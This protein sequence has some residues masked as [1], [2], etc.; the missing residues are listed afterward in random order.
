VTPPRRRLVVTV[1][2][3]ERGCVTLPPRRGDRPRRLDARAITGL[4]ESLVAARGLASIVAVET[5]CAGGCARPGPNVSVTTYPAARDGEPVS[6][7]AIAW[8]TYVYSLSRLASVERIVDD[9]LGRRPGA[10]RLTRSSLRAR[11][12]RAGAPRTPGGR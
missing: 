8:K 10:R 1:C 2:P 3:R 11:A 12:V 5:A 7:V 4:L 6:R 9:N